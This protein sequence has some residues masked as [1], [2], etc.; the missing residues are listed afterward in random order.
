M[1]IPETGSSHTREGSSVVGR[2]PVTAHVKG[3]TWRVGTNGSVCEGSSVAGE[4]P[5]AARFK[6][7]LLDARLRTLTH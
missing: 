1:G 3:R 7:A 4:K 5:V 2:K 6:K